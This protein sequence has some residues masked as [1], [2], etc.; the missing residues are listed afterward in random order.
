[1]KVKLSAAI[2][3]ITVLGLSAAASLLLIA[4]LAGAFAPQ[5]GS[6]DLTTDVAQ[7]T[8]TS[9]ATEQQIV[10][11]PAIEV[12]GTRTAVT[13]EP[14]ASAEVATEKRS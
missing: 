13:A 11:L 5:T 10:H 3:S 7:S 1:M 12:I 4:G 14:R 9:G 8:L 2:E 6:H